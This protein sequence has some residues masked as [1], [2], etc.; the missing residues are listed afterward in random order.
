[1][2]DF[3]LSRQ[4]YKDCHL[5]WRQDLCFCRHQYFAYVAACIT[6]DFNKATL[7]LLTPW[8]RVLLEKLTGFKLVKKFPAL[9]GT[10]RFSTAITSA[11]H[12]S[13]SWASSIGLYY[14]D[15]KFGF[16]LR[17]FS[18]PNLS[19]R[20]HVSPVYGIKS[21]KTIFCKHTNDLKW[22]SNVCVRVC[23]CMRVRVCVRACVCVCVCVCVHACV[24]V[25]VKASYNSP[26]T[27]HTGAPLLIFKLSPPVPEALW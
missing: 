16:N 1:M 13:L 15:L 18:S 14:S 24:C 12:L 11:H 9:Y 3:G 17:T 7:Y 27:T 23:A 26:S 10:Q 8:S 21:R 20:N 22:I 6:E 19:P 2:W 4:S 5:L 25:C